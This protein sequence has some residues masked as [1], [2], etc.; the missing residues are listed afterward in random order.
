MG[1]PPSKIHDPI[2]YDRYYSGSNI[3]GY[4]LLIVAIVF[5]LKGC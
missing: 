5:L 1:R 2:G 4:I 3:F